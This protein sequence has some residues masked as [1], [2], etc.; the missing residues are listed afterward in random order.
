MMSSTSSVDRE[1]RGISE[2]YFTDTSDLPLFSRIYQSLKMNPKTAWIAVLFK[3]PYFWIFLEIV[4]LI[5]YFCVGIMFYGENQGWGVGTTMFYTV[6]T[7]STVGKSEKYSIVIFLIFCFLK[8]YGYHHP[9]DDTSRLFTIFYIFVGVYFVFVLV[10][11][12][13]VQLL[14][15]TLRLLKGR[16]GKTDIATEYKYLNH[17]IHFNLGAILLTLFIGAFCFMGLEG[18]TFIEAFYFAVETST[19]RELCS[20]IVIF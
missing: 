8:G 3:S 11:E 9:T 4:G 20:I 16:F 18:W 10:A 14:S 6:V 13:L 5:L 19:V 17:L 15:N 7:M 12:H 1:D 2:I